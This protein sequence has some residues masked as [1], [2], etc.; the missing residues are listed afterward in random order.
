M[1]RCLSYKK[2]KALQ[3]QIDI[4]QQVKLMQGRVASTAEILLKGFLKPLKCTQYP[5]RNT[6]WAVF[7]DIPLKSYFKLTKSVCNVYLVMQAGN[8][9]KNSCERVFQTSQVYSVFIQQCRVAIAQKFHRK[10]L[11]NLL[12]VSDVCLKMLCDSKFYFGVTVNETFNIEHTMK[13]LCS[14]LFQNSC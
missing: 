14:Q 2:H 12:S 7:A 8:F 1:V 6:G 11:S 10:V 3:G 4:S 5:F 13:P 9:C